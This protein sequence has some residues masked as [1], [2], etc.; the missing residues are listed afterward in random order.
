MSP[1][2]S[3]RWQRPP[4]NPPAVTPC[5]PHVVTRAAARLQPVQR[6]FRMPRWVYDLVRQCAAATGE[7]ES[8]VLRAWVTDAAESW[9]ATAGVSGNDEPPAA[10]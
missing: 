7:S 4:Q 10:E 9:A 6:A 2:L 3:H 1:A 8:A 5:H